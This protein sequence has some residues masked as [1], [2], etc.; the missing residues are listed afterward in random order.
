MYFIPRNN[1]FYHVISHLN[2]TYRYFITFVGL[3]FIISVWFYGMYRPL[4]AKIECH[5]QEINQLKD[6]KCQIN[7]ATNFCGKLRDSIATL[8][9]EVASFTPSHNK[10]SHLQSSVL[11]ILEMA[12]KAGL[13]L[14][15]YNAGKERSK[16]WHKKYM[17]QFNFS[18]TILQ[19]TEFFN[20]IVL[21]HKIISCKSFSCKQIDDTNFTINCDMQIIAL[22]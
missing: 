19:L 17:A 22:S 13:S 12:H 14:Q 10:N 8:A 15:T 1:R 11:F 9:Q 4:E 6:N 16:Q 21:S 5:D 20:H 7:C 3:L 18:G 2:T